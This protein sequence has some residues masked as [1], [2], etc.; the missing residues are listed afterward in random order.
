M[1]GR[2]VIE[3]SHPLKGYIHVEG[4]KNAVLP[5]L[6]AVLLCRGT[7]IFRNCPRLSDV[8]SMV[9]ILQWLGCRCEWENRL[10]RV[11]ASQ[12]Y[13]HPLPGDIARVMRS[14]IFL[15]G[16]M[17]GRFGEAVCGYPGGCDIGKRPIDL[18]LSG[19]RAMGAQI[20]EQ[21]DQIVCPP[22]RLKGAVIQLA[23]PSV[24]ATENL[25]MAA[26]TAEG[27]TV[28][29]GAAREPEIVALMEMLNAMGARVE[30]AGTNTIRIE[31]VSADSLEGCT[32]EVKGDRIVAGTYLM[33]AAV[34][35]GEIEMAGAD[36]RQLGP[37]CGMLE[38]SGC[39]VNCDSGKIHLSAPE[40]LKAIGTIETR[41]YPGFATDL[42]APWCALCS[43]AE[44]ESHIAERIFED[45]FHHVKELIAMGA[46]I[47]LSGNDAYIRGVEK[48]NAAR[49]WAQDL[50]GGAALVIAA[51]AA[52][53]ISTIE[54]IHFIDRGYERLENAL[55]A[56]GAQIMRQL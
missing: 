3:G 43:V 45:R 38:R 20:R 14:S 18:H 37:L 29:H 11:D 56:L 44:G 54:N 31:G 23:F 53:G 13:L 17:L 42:Q 52:K 51:L 24:G 27:S 34:T 35:G 7:V 6:A 49:V 21:G 40:K 19:L 39:Q 41:P 46:D 26:V 48:L 25:M 28:I 10:L 33:A 9:W 32:I 36:P 30:G 12:A 50:R 4:A 55:T 47:C 15:L 5:M 8:E 22:C 1:S 2:F 16:P